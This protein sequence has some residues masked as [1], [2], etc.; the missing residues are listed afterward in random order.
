M[1]VVWR[2]RLSSNEMLVDKFGRL[3]PSVMLT[4]HD[5]IRLAAERKASD[6]FIKAGAPPNW[7]L[8]GRIA[9]VDDNPMLTPEDTRRMAYSVMSHE[10]IMQFEHYPELD[11]AIEIPEITRVRVNIHK[12]R[13]SV[14]MVLRLVPLKIYTLDMLGM[15]PAVGEMTKNRS[16]LVLV[17]GPTGS[18]KSTT[19]AA[20][21]NKVNNEQAKNII[22]V[23]DP[24]EFVHP[25]IKSIIS[26]R[27]VG[28]DTESFSDALKYVVRQNPDII[29][30]GEIRDVE[31]VSVALQAAETGHLVFGTL[32][33]SSASETLDRLMHL[34]PP[35]EKGL[36]CLRLATTLKGILSQKLLPRQDAAGR[37]AAVEIMVVTPT[38]S[39][40]IE[41]GRAGNIYTAIQ[42]GGFWGMQ[43]MNQCLARYYKA[44][45]I[46][47]DD[48]MHAAGNLTELRQMI[49]R[50]GA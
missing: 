29:L 15:P 1:R 42:E 39:K 9:A 37:V 46:T 4:V 44:G 7:R 31:T 47:E 13:N 28:I 32:H 36:L 41:E 40:L 18:G 16:G 20:M 2:S 27:E 8:H 43:T 26:Q 49:R 25:D 21:I 30:I 12:Q 38:V 11:L 50:P 45:I 22:T 10:Q 35:H 48:A 6:I 17:T 24:I 19:L 3:K 5:L 33:T 34:F 23:E 14:G